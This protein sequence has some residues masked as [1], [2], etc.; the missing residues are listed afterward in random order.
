MLDNSLIFSLIVG[1]ISTLVIYYITNKN[2]F[3]GQSRYENKELLKIFF[4]IFIS[5]FGLFYLRNMKTDV[6]SMSIKN[7]VPLITH[8]SRPP[9]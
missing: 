6:N 5:C 1:I 8:S 4:I 7:T 9:F 3:N 2:N